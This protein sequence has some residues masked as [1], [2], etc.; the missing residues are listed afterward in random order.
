MINSVLPWG[1]WRKK[2]AE[3]QK[4]LRC[5]GCWENQQGGLDVF[6]DLFRRWGR[7]IHLPW[8][9]P[10]GKELHVG[11]Q[12]ASPRNPQQHQDLTHTEGETYKAGEAW[13]QVL[14][15]TI[16]PW[17]RSCLLAWISTRMSSRLP[18]PTS[19]LWRGAQAAFSPIGLKVE[20]HR[21][22]A[23]SFIN[24][25]SSVLTLPCLWPF[26]GLLWGTLLFSWL[27]LAA[28]SPKRG[29]TAARA[30]RCA[31]F[32]FQCSA[33]RARGCA[34][35]D[36]VARLES[37][38]MHACVRIRVHAFGERTFPLHLRPADWN[39]S[40]PK[41]LYHWRHNSVLRFRKGAEKMC[42][43]SKGTVIRS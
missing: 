18:S 35:A 15:N 27:A 11:S 41:L 24:V 7:L 30:V 22:P 16:V 31:W 10:S 29:V 6:V 36:P 13:Q 17:W 26:P 12:T 8:S 19:A 9:V 21:A 42:C 5:L 3:G 28:A 20:V 4:A 34:R 32:A 39:P 37:W 33:R 2:C 25:T 38:D 1:C 40:K 43:C 23:A 14:F